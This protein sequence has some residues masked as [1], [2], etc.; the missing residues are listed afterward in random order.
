[1]SSSLLGRRLGSLEDILSSLEGADKALAFLS[2]SAKI[3]S[4][5]LARQ[6]PHRYERIPW[7]CIY[8]SLIFA[9]SG[10][11]RRERNGFVEASRMRGQFIDSLACLL[12]FAS[13]Y[14][15]IVTSRRRLRGDTPLN[16]R[17]DRNL[18]DFGIHQKYS[19]SLPTCRIFRSSFA[20][21]S[22]TLLGSL[23]ISWSSPPR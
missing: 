13:C 23:R 11:G 14:P 22:N 15:F 20:T 21:P 18:M 19:P 17:C 2:Y 12:I 9:H 3:L 16:I 1:M 5:L 10:S 8:D 6:Y 7:L 4:F